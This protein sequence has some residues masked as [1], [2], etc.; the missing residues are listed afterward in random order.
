MKLSIHL[1]KY[2]R[3]LNLMLKYNTCGIYREQNPFLIWTTYK[4][5][6]SILGCGV[7]FDSTVNFNLLLIQIQVF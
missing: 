4:S 1:F 7:N 3:H 6:A 5:L 2:L